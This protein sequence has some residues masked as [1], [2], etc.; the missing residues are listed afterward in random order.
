MPLVERSAIHTLPAHGH[1]HGDGDDDLDR[2]LGREFDDGARGM[3]S[4][5]SVPVALSEASTW[6][7]DEGK[8]V[9]AEMGGQGGQGW[10]RG[11]GS[12]STRRESGAA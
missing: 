6:G 3:D 1:G 10:T 2:A 4:P 9:E 12:G 8:V 5:D 7:D 11:R